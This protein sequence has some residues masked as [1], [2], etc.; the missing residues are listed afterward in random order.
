MASSMGL[1]VREGL[2]R[3]QAVDTHPAFRRQGLAGTLLY[4]A[5]QWGFSEMKA[6][7]LV[8]VA[9][10]NYFAKDLYRS[11]GFEPKERLVGL[12]WQ[13]SRQ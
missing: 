3:F 8:I 13:N 1:F 5:A 12:E 9:D 11:V 7:N 4:H 2:G 10:Q 6:K